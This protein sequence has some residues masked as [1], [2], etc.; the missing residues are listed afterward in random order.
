MSRHLR[1]AGLD[2]EL[3][4]AIVDLRWINAQA[5]AR[6]ILGLKNDL[7]ILETVVDKEAESTEIH[8][9]S[10]PQLRAPLNLLSRILFSFSASLKM[11]L[12]VLSF[13]IMTRLFLLS[14]SDDWLRRYLKLVKEATPKPCLVPIVSFLPTCWGGTEI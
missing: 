5:R 7:D 3:G 9:P 12:R 2:L 11:G 4:A 1:S 6:G 13:F 14:K 10:L 8:Y